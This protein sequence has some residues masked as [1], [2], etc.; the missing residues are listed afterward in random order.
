[1]QRPGDPRYEGAKLGRRVVGR[2]RGAA[3]ARGR[4]SPL[5]PVCDKL[6]AHLRGRGDPA[7][8]IVEVAGFGRCAN[9]M[10]SPITELLED[11]HR[12]EGAGVDRL[13][14]AVHGR[15]EAI[16][17]RE[18]AQRY[19]PRAQ[20]L[21]IEPGILADDALMKMLG[22]ETR[23]ENRRQFFAYATRIMVRALIDYQRERQTR[24]RGGGLVRVTLS[25]VGD[26]AP[27]DVDIEDLEAA[28]GALERLDCRKAT[29]V[30]LRVY[31]GMTVP[32]TAEVLQ[33][34][35][36]TVDREWR[37]ALRWLATRL[38]GETGMSGDEHR[39]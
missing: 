27:H 14:A 7:A 32:E 35:A 39:G 30:Q 5:S 29:L 28:L 20:A 36:S 1:M 10:D 22:K 3:G 19:G 25:R 11:L 17:Q 18:I 4:T 8:P 26:A 33:V 15:L 6:K 13:V 23:F 12:G 21:T 16:A 2:V 37:F 34:S 31:W 24:K 9:A 38:G